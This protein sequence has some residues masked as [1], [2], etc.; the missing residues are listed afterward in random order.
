VAG[1]PGQSVRCEPEY[2]DDSA[3]TRRSVERML[4]LPFAV[5]CLDH[6]PPVVKDPKSA[7]RALLRVRP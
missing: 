2:H 7:I 6:G 3:E 4:D 5:L 1:D